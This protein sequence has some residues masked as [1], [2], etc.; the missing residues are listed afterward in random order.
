MQR[1]CRIATTLLWSLP[2]DVRFSFVT[3]D[4]GVTTPW[5]RAR[6]TLKTLVSRVT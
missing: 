2:G 1:L 4:K 5:L 3:R 6:F